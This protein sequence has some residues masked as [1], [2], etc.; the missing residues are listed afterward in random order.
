MRACS[1]RCE[2]GASLAAIAAREG[3]TPRRMRDI[4]N[5]FLSANDGLEPA[6]GLAQMR[7][8]RRDQAL[9]TALE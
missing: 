5:Q 8:L 7:A 2:N 1:T 3:V 4:V 6:D 9:D